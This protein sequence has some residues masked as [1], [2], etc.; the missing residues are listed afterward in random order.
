MLLPYMVGLT[1]FMPAGLLWYA[2]WGMMSTAAV[3][4]AETSGVTGGGKTCQTLVLQ[5]DGKHAWL[6]SALQQAAGCPV[7]APA[8]QEATQVAR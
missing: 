3:L 8:V 6:G 1:V 5:W 4:R 7:H 2:A